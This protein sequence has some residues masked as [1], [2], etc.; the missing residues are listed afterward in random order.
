MLDNIIYFEMNNWF[1]GRDYPDCEPFL[2]WMR[3]L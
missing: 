3:D 1:A 2:T